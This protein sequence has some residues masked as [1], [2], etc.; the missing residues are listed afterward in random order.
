MIPRLL[1]QLF[2][3]VL[4]AALLSVLAFFI[5]AHRFQAKGPLSSAAYFEIPR[6]AV[7]GEIAASLKDEGIISES[8]I[9]RLGARRSGQ[10]SDIKFG[11]FEIPARASMAEIL[12][13]IV[14]PALAVTRHR[15]VMRISG[16]GATILISERL[17]GSGEIIELARFS[18]DDSA[19][20]IYDE[21]SN[22]ENGVTFRVAIAEGL[23]NRQVT[24]ALGKAAFL[25]G[26]VDPLPSEGSL[27][28]DTYDVRR[29]DSRSALIRRMA[30]RQ[31]EI[32][33]EA[34]SQR[35]PDLP[36]SRIEEALVLASIIEKETSQPDERPVIASVFTNRLRRG[37]KLQSDP[38]VVYAV[39]D[40]LG[41]LDH[42]LKKSELAFDSPYNTYIYFGLPPT[43]IANPGRDAIFATLQPAA[44]DYLFFVADGSGGHAFSETYEAH[45]EHVKA[46][47]VIENSRSNS[48]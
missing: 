40:G 21:I 38:T 12:D 32:L 41:H 2:A 48:D 13:L 4:V 3:A 45:R 6:G 44:T 37:M 46:W 11:T 23:T 42:G 22:L 16:G 27:A 17:A 25:S 26:D 18:A 8:L 24:E 5:A 10:A 39:S 7:I 14:Q 9:F 28:P 31:T 29:N 35:A 33:A 20:E 47:R 15:I 1:S 30:D 19:P 34:W 36:L 43:P